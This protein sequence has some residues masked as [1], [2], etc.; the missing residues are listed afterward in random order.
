LMQVETLGAASQGSAARAGNAMVRPAATSDARETSEKRSAAGPRRCGD[1]R[2]ESRG[3]MRATLPRSPGDDQTPERVHAAPI[4]SKK[5]GV[6]EPL[7]SSSPLV[8][9]SGSPRRREIL[10]RAG[11]PFVVVAGDANEDV[12]PG[13]PV[14][15]YLARVVLAKLASVRARLARERGEAGGPGAAILVADTSVVESGDILGKPGSE[16][17]ALAMISR[18]SARTH[19]VQTRFALA[20][21]GGS[22]PPLAAETVVTR[23]T[24]RPITPDEARR[25]VASGEGRDKAGGYAVQG[26]AGPFVARIDGS[27]SNVVGLPEDEVLAALRAL[28]LLP[29]PSATS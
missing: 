17:E 10:T 2:Q 3:G 23:V 25:Y 14:G 6:L 27:Y 28:G 11:V 4:A 15:A 13:E 9:G 18:L 26:G 20:G 22:A 16:G 24:F 12:L 1:T 29:A 5:T 7:S 19:E 21:A 8:L